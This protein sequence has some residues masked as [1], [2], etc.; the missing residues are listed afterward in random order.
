MLLTATKLILSHCT[1]DIATT[2]LD[3]ISIHLN[4]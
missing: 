2:G 3:V 4:E 1:Q